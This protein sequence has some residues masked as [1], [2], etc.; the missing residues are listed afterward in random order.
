MSDVHGHIKISRKAFLPL[1]QG[2]DQW[3]NEKRVFS[4]WEAWQ[5]MIQA[6]SWNDRDYALGG[7][8]VLH[9]V[10]GETFPLSI[11]FLMKAWGWGSKKRV[12]GFLERVQQMDRVRVQQR[13]QQGSTYLIVNYDHYQSSPEEAGT[14]A[15][16]AAGTPAGTNQKQVL[17]EEEIKNIRGNE[18][19]NGS[20]GRGRK[21]ASKTRGGGRQTWLTPFGDAWLK[22]V[23]GE[24][25]WGAMAT[26]LRKL[27]EKHGAD[28]VVGIWRYY[29]ENTEPQF[30]SPQS[31]ASKYGTWKKRQ[32]PNF[33]GFN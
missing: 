3:W 31:F 24:P 18:S 30:C 29:L 14:A 26:A 15:G 4:N 1:E 19:P 21:P 13:V 12:S 27:V 2:G 11:R 16:T 7:D 10:R 17:K 25:I 9:L 33:S 20:V 23:G 8:E 22:R 5:Y 6:A 28:E 32:Q